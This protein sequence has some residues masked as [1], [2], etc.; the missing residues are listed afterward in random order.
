MLN[1]KFYKHKAN[2]SVHK[3]LCLFS[4]NQEYILKLGSGKAFFALWN[5]VFYHTQVALFVWLSASGLTIV[6][7]SLE[8]ESGLYIFS[9]FELIK[10]VT[11]S[12][13]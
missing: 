12:L 5:I 7:W 6:T 4:A 1:V 9:M 11:I 8:L 10:V 13:I 3:Y 2:L